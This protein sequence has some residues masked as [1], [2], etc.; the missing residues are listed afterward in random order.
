MTG[1]GNRFGI[2]PVEMPAP[3]PRRAREPGPMG[4][5]V[6]ETASSV[7]ESSEALIEQRRQNAVD[8][9][10]W[11]AAHE[12]G[13]VLVPL[14]LD[15][16]DTTDLPRDRLELE[17]VAT[18]DEM[19]ELKSSIR[20]RGQRE[21]IEVF[22]TSDNRYELKKGW[23]R[24]T[25]L[26]QLWAETG[27]ARFNHVIARVTLAEE[28]RVD[29]YIDMVEENVIRQDLSFAEMAQIAIALA[30]DPIA[31][32]GDANAAVGRLYRSVHK[33]KRAYIRAFVT[34]MQELG[35][36]LP[37]PK[38]LSRDLGV[39]VAR[40]LGEGLD[41]ASLRL[42][43]RSC[44]DP[45]AQNQVLRNSLA[46]PV[47]PVEK[48]ASARQKLEFRVGESK[49]TARDGEFRIKTSLDFAAMDRRTLERAVRA[50]HQALA[51]R[52]A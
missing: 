16:V 45:E 36:D 19:D 24:L 40:R 11:R 10:Y 47:E 26:R 41:L 9:R 28:D 18:S 38:S 2:G 1:K 8:A 48:K 5:A 25:A 12:E 23:R 46:Q 27:D 42:A 21:P 13:R 4:V 52:D 34:L 35:E 49:V 39:E 14:A 3:A 30:A 51:D 22:R 50:F 29:L 33:V 31:E 44:A 17:A 20:E 15:L 37:F 43:L 32:V 6:R 7:Q